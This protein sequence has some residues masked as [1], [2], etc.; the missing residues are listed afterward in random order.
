[1]KTIIKKLS[2]KAH[3]IIPFGIV[4]LYLLIHFYKLTLLPVFADESIYIRWTQLIIDD[5]RRYLF[6]PMNDGK[7]PLHMWLMVPWQLVF[8]DKLFAGRFLSV[9]VGLIQIF[10]ISSIIKQLGGRKK[11]QWLSMLLVTII[12]FWFFH[13]RMA[14]TDGLTTMFLSLTILFLTKIV[15][16]NKIKFVILAGI[17]FGLALLSKLPA[18]LFTPIFLWVLVLPK[19]TNYKNNSKIKLLNKTIISMMI[20][21]GIFILLKLHPTFGQLFSRGNDFLFSFSDLLAGKT[22]SNTFGNIFRFSNILMTYL[23][24]PIMILSF[25]GLFAKKH[26]KQQY[27]LWLISLSFLIPITVLGKVVYP[28]YLLPVAIPFTISA[29]IALQNYVDLLNLKTH[30]LKKNK[31]KFVGALTLALL[32]ANIISQSF[33]FI[34]YAVTDTSN[35]PF[36]DLDKEQYLYEWSSGHGITETVS[37]INKESKNKK[38]FVA[39]EGYFGTLP[40]ALLMNL[41]RSDTSNI[42]I[43]G[44]GQPVVEISEKTKTQAKDFDQVV[45]VVNSH[46]MKMNIDEDKLITQFCRPE[47]APCLQIWDI[48]EIIKNH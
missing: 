42:F 29:L 46:R 13:H 43:E 37:W 24:P 45:L 30:F 1:M 48:T 9:I 18:I 5:W 6:F 44:I 38:I 31:I 4:F 27:F 20:G 34:Y 16:T 39:T 19:S 12:P 22:I 23:T 32:T 47:K 28:R 2:K 8:E 15:S 40:D 33:I 26:Q 7:T 3:W 25:A 10:S 41:H 35:I 17:T 36:V 21:F 14:L 11:I